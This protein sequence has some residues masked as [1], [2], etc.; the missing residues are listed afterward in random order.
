[1]IKPHKHFPHLNI[2]LLMGFDLISP[3]G[4]INL[5]LFRPNFRITSEGLG[6]DNITILK[7]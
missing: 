3:I 5:G 1:M 7:N 2:S 6:M 4:L